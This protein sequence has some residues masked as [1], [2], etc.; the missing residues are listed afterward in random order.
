[1]KID[2]K[3]GEPFWRQIGQKAISIEI[4]RGGTVQDLINTLS[5]LYPDLRSYLNEAEVPPTIFLNDDLADL[6][7]QLHD[8]D[9]PTLIWAVSGG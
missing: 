4:P 2:V 3:L 9:C 8:G 6:D 7:T 5:S 1:M